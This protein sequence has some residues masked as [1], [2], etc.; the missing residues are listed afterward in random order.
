MRL[1]TLLQVTPRSTMAVVGLVVALWIYAW[2]LPP[3]DAKRFAD[4]DGPVEM[5]SNLVLAVAFAFAGL[6]LSKHPSR[7]WLSGT[8]MSLWLLLR[9]FDFQR[10]FTHRSVESISYYVRPGA[11]WTEKLLVLLILAPFGLAGLHLLRLLVR[12]FRPAFARR[13]PWTLHLLAAIGLMAIGTVSEK[14]FLAGSAEE[15]CELGMELLILL[16][17]LDLRNKAK[18]LAPAASDAAGVPPSTCKS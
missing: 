17:V 9:E 16:L 2:A 6:G 5:A 15:I 13:E 4:E 18:L 14:L 11:P 10:C 12:H 8:A 1:R 3:S 7:P